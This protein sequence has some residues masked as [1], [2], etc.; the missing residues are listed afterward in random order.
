LVADP[1]GAQ[2]TEQDEWRWVCPDSELLS[3]RLEEHFGKILVFVREQSRGLSFYEIEQILISLVFTL[4]RLCLALCLCYR[5]EELRPPQAETRQGRTFK[6]RDPQTRLLG[7]F[8]GKVR[9]WRTYMYARGGGYY[10]LDEQLNMPAD[11]FSFHLCSLIARLATK[12][13]YVQATLVL[14]CFLGWSP[15]HTTVEHT[16]FGLGRHTQAFFESAPIPEDEGEVMVIMIDSKATPTATEEELK[17]RRGPRKPNRVPGSPRHRGRAQRKRRGPRKRRKKGDKSKN[18]KMATLV[19]MYTL[20][21]ARAKDDGQ[22]VLLGPINKRLYASYAPK[23][24]AFA[25]ARREADRR[26]FHRDSGKTLQLVTDG[27][28]D[29]SRYAKELFPEAI[30]TLDVIHV[31]EWLWD[32]G[33]SLHR[34]GTDELATWVEDQKT[35]LYDGD[36]EEIL[37]ELSRALGAIPKTGPGNKGR[38]KRLQETFN[39]LNKRVTMMNYKELLEK[40]LEIS[41]GPVEGAVRNVIAQRFDEGGMRWIK[42]SA[43]ALL[44]LRCIEINGQW[45][46]FMKFIHATGW[47]DSTNAPPKGLTLQSSAP[48]PLPSY[49]LGA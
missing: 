14:R 8:F 45:D 1:S 33:R 38:R 43:E 24:H 41:S 40:D 13:S 22:P 10:P 32:A 23:R 34:E 36:V 4:G 15:S 35:R 48:Q 25:V 39:Y 9:Y 2:S 17:K 19:V 21:P 46:D 31:V 11:G 49:G 16:V 29:L 26:G 44:Q 47:R 28:R 18:G 27:D 7:T 42:E 5:H 30:H 20:R 3:T 6:R 37:G 12:M